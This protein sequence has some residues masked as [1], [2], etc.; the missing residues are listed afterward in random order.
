MRSLPWLAGGLAGLALGGSGP[1]RAADATAPLE[2]RVRVVENCQ[3]QVIGLT[4]GELVPGQFRHA[5][6]SLS[7]KCPAG[8]AYQITVDAGQHYDGS[9]RVRR[10]ANATGDFIPYFILKQNTPDSFPDYWGD[11]GY[12]GSYTD[13]QP[14]S[15]VGDGTPQQ[16]LV[17]GQIDYRGNAEARFAKGSYSDQVLVTLNY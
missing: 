15:R 5:Q 14:L 2:V 8:R 7:V 1:A 9:Q 4:F 6:S 12:G 10:M 11:A 17:F 16:A 13:G 3:V